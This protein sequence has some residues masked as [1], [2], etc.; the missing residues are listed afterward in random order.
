MGR[1]VVVRATI[2]DRRSPRRGFGSGTG[3]PAARHVCGVSTLTRPEGEHHVSRPTTSSW[4]GCSRGHA[5]G[6]RGRHG[7]GGSSSASV[8][9]SGLNLTGMWK[10]VYHCRT[11]P[12]SGAKTNPPEADRAATCDAPGQPGT[13]ATSGAESRH[14]HGGSPCSQDPGFSLTGAPACSRVNVAILTAGAK[15]LSQTLS[16]TDSLDI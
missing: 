11:A 3:L 15:E 8:L 2:D 16:H 12:S 14:P 4:L 1:A 7:G 5:C 6:A 10:G 13:Q 9:G